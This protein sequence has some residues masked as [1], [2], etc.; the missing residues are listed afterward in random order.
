[1]ALLTN[2]KLGSY[3]S[4]ASKYGKKEKGF[5]QQHHG[6]SE[7]PKCAPL[8]QIAN[9]RLGCKYLPGTNNHLYNVI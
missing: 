7:T 9:V 6:M 5:R 3:F 8:R 4:I 2:V 1:M